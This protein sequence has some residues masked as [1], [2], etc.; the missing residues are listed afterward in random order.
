MYHDFVFDTVDQFFL[1]IVMF[2][3]LLGSETNKKLL[4]GKKQLQ[5]AT[6]IVIVNL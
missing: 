4:K 2:Y 3:N 5:Q 1:K 6:I